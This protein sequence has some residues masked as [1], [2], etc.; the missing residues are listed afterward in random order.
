MGFMSKLMFLKKHDE[1]GDLG[2]DLG[3]DFTDP[4][5][6][7]DPGLGNNLGLGKDD[8]GA[9]Q[10]LPGADALGPEFG[11]VSQRPSSQRREMPTLE[12]VNAPSYGGGANYAQA[13]PSRVDKD[14]EII[15]VKL[16]NIRNTLEILNQRIAR[17]ERIAEGEQQQQRWV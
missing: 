6:G 7:S 12:P 10:Q 17:I 2:K 14:I 4:G 8:F 3:G 11:N 9:A 16:D 5:L 1:F 13:A 15:S